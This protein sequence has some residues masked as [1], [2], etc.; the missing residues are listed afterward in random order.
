[1]FQQI[2]IFIFYG[3]VTKKLLDFI[4]ILGKK[5]NEA[6]DNTYIRITEEEILLWSNF[7][8]LNEVLLL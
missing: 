3:R 2:S 8:C 1:M 5:G 6:V 7:E 4:Y